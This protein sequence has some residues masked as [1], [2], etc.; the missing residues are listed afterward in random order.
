MNTAPSEGANP[1][2]ILG[3]PATG[4]P[5]TRARAEPPLWPR[6][7]PVKFGIET[8][9]LAAYCR[10]GGVKVNVGEIVFLR[11]LGLSQIF[12]LRA[13]QDAIYIGVS[14]IWQPWNA[15]KALNAELQVG[16]FFGQAL[17]GRLTKGA[18]VARKRHLPDFETY[19]SHASSPGKFSD[20]QLYLSAAG[21]DSISW[22]C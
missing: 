6:G 11:P 12:R 22:I 1:S 14:R 7:S 21:W 5:R 15:A 13:L 16:L 10:S 19:R 9:V 8:C 3:L 20:H 2:S 18:L 17:A 4:L